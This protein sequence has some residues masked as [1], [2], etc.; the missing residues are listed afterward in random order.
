M[1]KFKT[2]YLPFLVSLIF[3]IA[4]YVFLVPSMIVQAFGFW[5][6]YLPFWLVSKTYVFILLISSLTSSFLKD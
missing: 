5:G 6:I 4:V 2:L 1:H 3:V